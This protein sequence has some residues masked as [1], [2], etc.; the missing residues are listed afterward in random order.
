MVGKPSLDVCFTECP[1]NNDILDVYRI[2]EEILKIVTQWMK[3]VQTGC[4]F[5]DVQVNFKMNT[6]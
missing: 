5:A 6:F 4:T 2:V 3:T 1:F